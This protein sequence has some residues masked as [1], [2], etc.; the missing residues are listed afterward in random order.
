MTNILCKAKIVTSEF[1]FRDF[2][3]TVADSRSSSEI[4][5]FLCRICFFN[6]LFSNNDSSQTYK[7]INA[8][9][10]FRNFQRIIFI[11]TALFRFKNFLSLLWA[12]YLKIKINYNFVK[13]DSVSLTFPFF[14]R[15][16]LHFSP[17]EIRTKIQTRQKNGRESRPEKKGDLNWHKKND[18]NFLVL[19]M[20]CANVYFCEEEFFLK[21]LT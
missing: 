18:N 15:L 3:R 13:L 5:L 4:W 6:S 10:F 11:S 8:Y 9:I 7:K 14:G 2:S 19:G 20:I 17:K 16:F 21:K 1:V 12:F